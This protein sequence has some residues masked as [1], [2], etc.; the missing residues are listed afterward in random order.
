MYFCFWRGKNLNFWLKYSLLYWDE[1]IEVSMHRSD[2]IQRCHI[3]TLHTTS[4]LF[5]PSQK[6]STVWE[7]YMVDSV[8][9]M[10]L[11][12]RNFYHKTGGSHVPCVSWIWISVKN[13]KTPLETNLYSFYEKFSCFLANSWGEFCEVLIHKKLCE[14]F[15]KR[16]S[17]H[18]KNKN[19]FSHIMLL[20]FFYLLLQAM[21]IQYKL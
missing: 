19:M 21:T 7:I 20:W 2:Q 17:Y 4:L 5:E 16:I 1:L 14:T 15:R 8:D 18:L 13:W 9:Q 10:M 12:I 3:G 11:V 6:C